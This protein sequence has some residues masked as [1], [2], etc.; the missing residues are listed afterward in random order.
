MQSESE[1]LLGDS[2]VLVG[3]DDTDTK[4]S[5]HGT[6]KISRLL[7]AHLSERLPDLEWTGCV[8]QQLLIDPRVPYT[9]HNSSATLLCEAPPTMDRREV[10]EPAIDFLEA[11]AADG[12]DPGLCVGRRAD[13][14]DAVRE[15]GVVADERLLETREAYELARASDLFLAACGGTGEGVIGALAGVGRTASGECGRFIEYG[16]IRSYAGTEP[17]E[18]LRSDGIDVVTSEGTEVES[19]TLATAGWVRPLLRDG[20]PVLEVE[21]RGNGRYRATNADG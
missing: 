21:A 12:S 4:D 6:G 5:E 1:S 19:G 13:V 14:A 8:R 11:N 10:V 3:I 18:R 16:K 20:S 15:F 7:G 17:V 2:T 9:T